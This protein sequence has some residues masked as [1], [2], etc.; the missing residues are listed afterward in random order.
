MDTAVTKRPVRH[1]RCL[2]RLCRSAASF[3]GET[4]ALSSK[5]PQRGLVLCVS[6]SAESPV[7]ASGRHSTGVPEDVFGTTLRCASSGFL[8]SVASL[9]MISHL[10][11]PVVKIG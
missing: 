11:S 2:R 4:V 7:D 8:D 10:A 9:S 3:P 5:T 1:R 6:L